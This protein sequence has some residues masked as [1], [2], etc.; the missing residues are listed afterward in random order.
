[1]E[2]T[3]QK[4]EQSWVVD[5]APALTSLVSARDVEAIIELLSFHEECGFVARDA[6]GKWHC[7]AGCTAM[8]GDDAALV[9][10]SWDLFNSWSP[11][12][13]SG[14][15]KIIYLSGLRLGML[16]RTWFSS[17]TSYRKKHPDLGLLPLGSNRPAQPVVRSFPPGLSG[18]VWR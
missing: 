15:G 3:D 8:D 17:R 5:M 14:E 4:S 13:P 11:C 7:I 1:M 6:S 16:R 10:M 18:S 9:V 12:K 2:K